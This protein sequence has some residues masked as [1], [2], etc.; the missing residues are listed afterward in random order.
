MSDLDQARIS[1]LLTTSE[2]G[3][4]LELKESTAST[5]DDARRAAS[6]GAAHGHVIVADAQTRGRGSRGRDWLSPRGTDLYVS[7]VA[8]L[9][10]A[11]AE[12]P[13]LTLTVGLAVAEAL[14]ESL[15]GA[16]KAQVKWPNDVW[17]GRKKLAGVLV[18]S[19]SL[20]ERLEPLV[21]GVGVNVNR[22]AFPGELAD[23]ASS[24][25]LATG[26][27]HDRSMVLARLL[28]Q[29]ELWLLRFVNEGPAPVLAALSERLALLGEH[30]TCD[31]MRGVVEGLHR[32]GALLLRDDAGLHLCTTGTLRPCEPA[33]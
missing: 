20:G 25:S 32:T 15:G 2:L 18:E 26:K 8:K 14:D 9:P 1:A 12:L 21:I 6:A 4:T 29:L 19:A 5:N 27:P 17:V 30:A 31:D 11:P 3:R 7:V 28:V 24:L 22:T 16:L 10:L 13:P 33:D 23:S